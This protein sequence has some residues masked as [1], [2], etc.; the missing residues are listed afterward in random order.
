MGQLPLRIR[1]RLNRVC[2]Q[3]RVENLAGP[4]GLQ[5]VGAGF[6]LCEQ[7]KLLGPGLEVSG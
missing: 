2:I 3:Q 5:L 1:P 7:C 4:P 6:I